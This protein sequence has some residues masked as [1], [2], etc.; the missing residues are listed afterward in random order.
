M[1]YCAVPGCHNRSGK[2]K[3]ED[4]KTEDVKTEDV[5]T[6][7]VKTE[8]VKG[9]HKI[10]ADKSLK[11]KWIVVIKRELPYPDDENFHVC[12]L[13]FDENVFERDLMSDILRKSKK[14]L[15]I[16]KKIHLK[17][18]AVPS[19]FPFSEVKQKRPSNILEET[20]VRKE[21]LNDTTMV[22]D[23]CPAVN[24]PV[25]EA[26]SS[27]CITVW[28]DEIDESNADRN[29]PARS[30]DDTNNISF[31][32]TINDNRREFFEDDMKFVMSWKQIK[33]LF[34]YCLNCGSLAEVFQ[35]Y[36]KGIVLF[37]KLE[38]TE[39]HQITWSSN[40]TSRWNDINSHCRISVNVRVKYFA[41]PRGYGSCQN[42][43]FYGQ[44]IQSHTRKCINPIYQC[45]LS[46]TLRRMVK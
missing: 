18:E 17:A 2:V 29:S 19:I 8:D 31:L 12:G 43:L 16:K 37:V 45:S 3:T 26:G 21:I 9:W 44:N 25:Q 39:G 34:H 35:V 30:D 24:Q 14:K 28:A 27:N 36:T 23:H 42:R 6:E 22:E 38:C 32:E 5:K 7:D 46:K 15:K 33:D 41:I 20:R 13:H 1:P 40:S 4:V 10:P 11:R